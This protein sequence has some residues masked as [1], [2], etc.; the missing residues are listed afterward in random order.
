MLYAMVLVL[1]LV[2]LRRWKSNTNPAACTPRWCSESAR[3]TVKAGEH[4]QTLGV[5][6]VNET[7]R[8]E[9][10]WVRW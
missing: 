5:V 3:L 7:L 6:M 8:I 10:H 2:A 1:V 4:H 9:P